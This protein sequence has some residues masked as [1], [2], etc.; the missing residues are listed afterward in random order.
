MKTC[1]NCIHFWYEPPRYDQPHPE[2]A[3]TKEHW[4]G[5]TTTEELFEATNC[6]DHKP[7]HEE[8]K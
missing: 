2:Y 6:R 7:K 4:D 1:E 8:K 3:C 5:I